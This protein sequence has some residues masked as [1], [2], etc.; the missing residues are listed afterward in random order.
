MKSEIF[1][2][3]AYKEIETNLVN[4]LNEYPDFLSK[5]TVLI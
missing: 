3:K 1:Y 2:T 4:F 5:N